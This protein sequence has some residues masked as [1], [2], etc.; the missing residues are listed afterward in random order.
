L[1][2]HLDFE[3]FDKFSGNKKAPVERQLHQGFRSL[4]ARAPLRNMSIRVSMQFTTHKRVEINMNDVKTRHYVASAASNPIS[5]V[6]GPTGSSTGL[7]HR[8]IEGI[9]RLLSF[10]RQSKAIKRARPQIDSEKAR[11]DIKRTVSPPPSDA[12]AQRLFNRWIRGRY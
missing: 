3:C 4:L 7:H 6:R 11:K 10:F 12:E 9:R 1:I 5:S 2:R 8:T